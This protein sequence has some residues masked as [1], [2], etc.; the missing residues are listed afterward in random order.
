MLV[1]GSETLQGIDGERHLA[2]WGGDEID[3]VVVLCHSLR[4]HV[5][6][7]G[8]FAEALVNSGAQV[9][10]LDQAG[11]GRSEGSPALI[12][13]F[14]AGVDDQRLVLQLV[15]ARHSD[16][17]LVLLGHGTGATLAVRLAQHLQADLA[18]LVLAAPLL[19]TVPGRH[20]DDPRLSIEPFHG[21]DLSRDPAVGGRFLS[22]PLVWHGEVPLCTA[23]ALH[24]GLQAIGRGPRLRL[25]V[26]R[27]HG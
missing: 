13:D 10:A 23:A 15:R 6:L 9:Y 1:G 17:P 12:G 21:R 2:S 19:G 8:P 5:G 3:R 7:Y 25:P 14:E 20:H 24:G 16:V 4:E 26:L 27:L 18:A 22:D 11:H